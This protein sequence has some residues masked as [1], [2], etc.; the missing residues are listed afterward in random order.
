[1]MVHEATLASLFTISAG[2]TRFLRILSYPL[3]IDPAIELLNG[4]IVSPY[5]ENFFNTLK[6]E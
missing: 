3:I 5:V 1:M 6:S 2:A 4:L